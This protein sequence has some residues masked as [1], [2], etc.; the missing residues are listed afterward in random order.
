LWW[1]WIA[2]AAS[3]SGLGAEFVWTKAKEMTSFFNQFW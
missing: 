2:V 3:L 1:W